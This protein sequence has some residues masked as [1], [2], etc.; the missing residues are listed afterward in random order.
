MKNLLFTPVAPAL[1]L[2]IFLTARAGATLPNI[3]Y[4]NKIARESATFSGNAHYT[5]ITFSSWLKATGANR[6]PDMSDIVTFQNVT[7][8]SGIVQRNCSWGAAWGDYDGD[9]NLDVMTVGHLLKPHVSIC[10]LWRNN[11]DGTFSDVTFAAGLQQLA[12]DCHGAVWA[13]MDSDGDLDLYVAK[14]TSKTDPINYNELWINN[15]DGTFTNVASTSGVTGV[16]YHNRGVYAID[17]DNDSDLDLFVASF[18]KNNGGPNLLYRNDGGLQFTDVAGAAGL[19]RSGIENLTAAWADFDDDGLIDVFIAMDGGLYRNLGDGTFADVTAAAGLIPSLDAQGGAWGDYDNDGDLDL[20]VT[21]GA[22]NQT[23]QGIL[24][25]NNGDGTFTDVTTQ[26]GVINISGAVGVDWGD[27]DNDGYL[28]LYIVNSVPGY[29]QPNR[30]F[31]NNGDG[32]FTDVALAARVGAKTT[33]GRGSDGTFVDFNNDGFLDLF[34]CNGEGSSYGQYLLF[35]NKTNSN[36]WLKITLVGTLSNR[37]G[38]GAKLWLTAGGQTQFREYTGQH[39]MSQNQIP[40][41]F[42][43][44]GATIVDSVTIQWP[45][46]ITQSLFTVPI[47]QLITVTESE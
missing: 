42:G 6:P 40:V 37:G 29:T 47:N 5:P 38:I 17:Y 1:L 22:G 44:G 15:G 14:G 25:Q 46:G 4:P 27:Y 8:Q 13:D 32:T 10:Q 33:G 31:R 41:H 12:G 7:L 3:S 28:D 43:V 30:L 21:M 19:Q 34:V 24:Y 9:G 36:G 16:G 39:H 45:S 23:A 11:G 18:P 35:Q 2:G 26:S 20:Y